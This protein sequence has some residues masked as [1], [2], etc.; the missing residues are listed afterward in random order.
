[1]ETSKTSFKSR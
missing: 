1:M